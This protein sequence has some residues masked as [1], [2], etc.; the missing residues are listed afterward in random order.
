[1][2]KK[3]L[4]GIALLFF[5]L[6]S[7]SLVSAAPRYV[8]TTGSDSTD[9]SNSLTPC[10]TIQYAITQSISGDTVNVA[11]GTYD[12]FRIEGKNN[13]IVQG[14][15][16][17]KISENPVIH[18]VGSN[19]YKVFVDVIDSTGITIKGLTLDANGILGADNGGDRYF[20]AIYYSNSGGTIQNNTIKNIHIGGQKSQGVWVDADGD[21]KI[22][23][24]TID[25]FGKGAIVVYSATSVQIERNTITTTDH[26]IAPNGIQIGYLL[27]DWTSPAL[28]ITGTISNN[29]VSDC[30]YE[31]YINQGYGTDT[32]SGILIMDTTADLEISN[33]DVHDN[34]VGMDIEAGSSTTMQ[35]NKIYHNAYGIVS[36]NEYPSIN[37]NSIEDND[38]YGIFR[39][40][41]SSLTGILNAENNWW[42]CSAGPG[43]PGCDTVSGDVDF[44]PWLVTP[45]TVY[46]DDDYSVGNSGSYLFGYNAFNKIQD[47]IN[48]VSAG[49][50]VNVAAGTYTERVDINKA[51]TLK[52]PNFG[53]DPNTRT[54]VS[55]AIIQT[56]DLTNHQAVLIESSD[57]IAD[58]FTIYG[59]NGAIKDIGAVGLTNTGAR[60]N[61]HIQY[62]RI[63]RT[64]G[65]SDYTCDGIR[66]DPPSNNDA[67]IFIEHNLINV[68]DAIQSAGNN[69][70]TLAD[71]GYWI[72]NHNTWVVGSP[73]R[74]VIK[75]NYLYGHSKMYIEG[76]GVLIDNNKFL[77]IWG[78]I[79][80]RGSKDVVI[81]NNEMVD[82][83]DVGIYAW[84][85]VAGDS[86]AGLC[87]DIT[88]SK[89]I[90]QEM[91][92]DPQ[93]F[94]D[95]GTA[96]ILGGVTNALVEKNNI[97][98][99]VGSGIVIS[100]KGYD[101]FEPT[102]T[103]SWGGALEVGDY[104][105]VNNVIL[106]NNMG[107]NSQ[108]GV[109]VDTTVTSGIPI[110]AE[111]N[112]WGSSSG[113]YH[114]TLNPS[115]TGDKVSDNVLFDPWLTFQ[116]EILS[117]TKK[118]LKDPYD[119]NRI[120]IEVTTNNP[121]DKATKIEYSLNGGKSYAVLCRNCYYYKKTLTFKQGEN[122]LI[123][124]A[125]FPFDNSYEDSVTFFVDSINPRII[126]QYP[127]NKRYTNGT[128]YVTYTEENL[129]NV[130]LFYKGTELDYKSAGPITACTA[131]KNQKCFFDISNELKTYHPD[132]TPITYYFVVKDYAKHEAKSRII[133]TETVDTSI[134]KI[135][136]TSPD[137]DIT[138][139]RRVPI[140]IIVSDSIKGVN[141]KYSIDSGRFTTLCSSC[142]SINTKKTLAAGPHTLKVMATD[143]AGNTRTTDIISFTV[144]A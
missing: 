75:N 121:G 66:L 28:G 110:N 137:P 114:P 80:V 98:N 111:N 8:A 109:K 25:E 106:N 89:N 92:L 97:K 44:D 123:V 113:P 129:D 91:K 134:P 4:S 72:N 13:L 65:G 77:G 140:Q 33:N 144:A 14:L 60:T 54:R 40:T 126:N 79:E 50:T 127:S 48:A 15:G 139:P 57:V 103:N 90:I 20:R 43:N 125:T 61:V 9:C 122:T 82:Q 96:I 63:F 78:P 24:N 117:P 130:V 41:T 64:S 22:L 36:W 118:P 99:N 104:Q 105:P 84:S 19:D 83:T 27:P 55:E 56:D 18:T 73:D 51:L 1:M 3:I 138:Q 136:V 120:P 39:T 101:H 143:K 12:G 94:T 62:N 74:V 30:H 2:K 71:H 128:F 115:G 100:G 58:G 34:D 76:I 35:N 142:D 135:T 131:G 68:G 67:T 11:A 102:D 47:G 23:D 26:S 133:Y 45:T 49:G 87:S 21:I 59:P 86:G 53:I 46:V 6:F 88:I 69:D 42:G 37:Y 116:L 52:G 112:W 81:S 16:N 85:P 93:D 124:R 10:Q 5:I 141:L 38:E 29:K 17:V 107:G 7:V 70:I 132:G 32:G 95:E 108:Y 119:T 31:G